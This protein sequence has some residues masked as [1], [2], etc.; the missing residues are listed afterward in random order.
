[1]FFHTGLTLVAGQL[2][3][4]APEEDA[5]W[6]FVSIM[7]SHLRPYFSTTTVQIDIDANLFSRIVEQNDGQLAKK[8]YI[9]FGIKPSDVCAVWLVLYWCFFCIIV[10]YDYFAGSLLSSLARCRLIMSIVSGMCSSSRVSQGLYPDDKILFL[11]CLVRCSLPISRG[12]LHRDVLPSSNSWCDIARSRIGAPSSSFVCLA[13][14]NSRQ[15]LISCLCCQD[16][17]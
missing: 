10:S 8:I 1:M 5:F 16:E 2:L 7:D 6:I 3:S 4:H 12:C 9:D 15:L 13:S 14:L 11:T 17:G